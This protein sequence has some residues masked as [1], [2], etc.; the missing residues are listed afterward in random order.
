LRWLALGCLQ[1]FHY[2]CRFLGIAHGVAYQLIKPEAMG[3]S[4]PPADAN[5]APFGCAAD[6]GPP[7]FQDAIAM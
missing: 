2:F 7:D 5:A 3:S 4:S 6:S 1:G